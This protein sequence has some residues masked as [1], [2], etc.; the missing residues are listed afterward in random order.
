VKRLG[1]APEF[2][3]KAEI[4]GNEDSARPLGIEPGKTLEFVGLFCRAAV[5]TFGH[6]Q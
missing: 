1:E 3:E 6:I 4:P 2:K 5:G